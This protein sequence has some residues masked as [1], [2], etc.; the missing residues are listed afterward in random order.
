MLDIEQ[1]GNN[2]YLIFGTE[3]IF[4]GV[5]ITFVERLDEYLCIILSE[6]EMQ[7]FV[8]GCISI[9]KYKTFV[10][11]VGIP[12]EKSANTF[13]RMKLFNCSHC[14]GF[15]KI[16]TRTKIKIN[17]FYRRFENDAK[18][19]DHDFDCEYSVLQQIMNS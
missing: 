17:G 7:D 8:V 1:I 2:K 18:F 9:K 14:S 11:L 4:K 15:H 3:V 6:V 19:C 13:S 16:E 5:D 10:G 12:K